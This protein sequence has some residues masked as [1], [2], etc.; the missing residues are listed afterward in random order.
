VNGNG[1]TPSPAAALEALLFVADEPV[2]LAELARALDVSLAAARGLLEALSESLRG[3][4]LRI[5]RQGSRVQM[6]T[7][8]ECGPVI[9]RFLGAR[10]EQRLS[11]AALET[12]AIIAYKQP[13]T[14]PQIEAIRGVDSGRAIATLRARE[15]VADVGRGETVGRPVLLGTTMRFLEHFGLEHPADLPPLPQGIDLDGAARSPQGPED[16]EGDGE[17]R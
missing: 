16:A 6:V 12:L 13:V 7:A 5:Q 14:R 11:P 1:P 4:G 10:H 15:L 17:G 9:E 8:P 2:E 3:R